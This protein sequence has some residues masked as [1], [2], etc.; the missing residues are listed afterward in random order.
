MPNQST[1]QM[2]NNLFELI[3]PFIVLGVVRVLVSVC[4]WVW[5]GVCLCV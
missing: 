1:R 2:A 5:L 4:V 3:N